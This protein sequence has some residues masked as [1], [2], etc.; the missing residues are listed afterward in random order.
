MTPSRGLWHRRTKERHTLFSLFCGRPLLHGRGFKGPCAQRPYHPLCGRPAAVMAL[1]AGSQHCCRLVSFRLPHVRSTPG[2]VQVL[3]AV[4]LA[5]ESSRSHPLRNRL[6]S[7]LCALFCPF[8]TQIIYCIV[9]VRALRLTCAVFF[10]S[11]PSGCGPDTPVIFQELGGGAFRA[12]GS[13]RVQ[14]LHAAGAEA[15]Q[16]DMFSI[17]ELRA[18]SEWS[19]RRAS[20]VRACLSREALSAV[21]VAAG[22]GL[23]GLA[24]FTGLE[25]LRVLLCGV[26]S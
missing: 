18:L 15:S 7:F 22:P 12:F 17:V 9:T 16:R 20:E 26:S 25:V 5:L 14:K 8:T 19:P 23:P 21:T 6:L 3:E 1:C 24:E 2:R 11:C 4:L 13:S 10:G